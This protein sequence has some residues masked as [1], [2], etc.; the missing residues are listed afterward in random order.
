MS[1]RLILRDLPVFSSHFVTGRE[2]AVLPAL[3]EIRNFKK[4]QRGIGVL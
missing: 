1:C 4:R 2:C 3:S